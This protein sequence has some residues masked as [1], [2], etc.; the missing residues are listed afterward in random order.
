[1]TLV[2][3][4]VILSGCPAGWAAFLHRMLQDPA[5][6]LIWWLY[7]L[8]VLLFISLLFAICIPPKSKE[9]GYKSKYETVCSIN[10]PDPEAAQMTSAHISLDCPR[11]HTGSQQMWFCHAL[12]SSLALWGESR[13]GRTAGSLCHQCLVLFPK[14][15][16]DETHWGHWYTDSQAFPPKKSWASLSGLVLRTCVF[17]NTPDDYVQEK[18]RNTVRWN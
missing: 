8:P 4:S 14:L 6:L 16:G 15:L 9:G 7:L 10:S 11:P 13:L 3:L 12:C 2:F 1:M 18:L 17:T 5:F